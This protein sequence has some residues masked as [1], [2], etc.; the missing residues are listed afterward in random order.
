VEREGSWRISNT[1]PAAQAQLQGINRPSKTR[2]TEGHQSINDTSFSI[3]PTFWA[4]S[5]HR[6]SKCWCEK[7]YG[8]SEGNQQGNTTTFPKARKTPRGRQPTKRKPT[9]ERTKV[10]TVLKKGTGTRL[11]RWKQTTIEPSKSSV[12]TELR[13]DR[14]KRH[15]N[16]AP[17]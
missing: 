14:S 7:V 17:F 8:G 1:R 13:R 4:T 12:D 3:E 16:I 9:P 2:T 10:S 15:P 6:H 5:S 11:P